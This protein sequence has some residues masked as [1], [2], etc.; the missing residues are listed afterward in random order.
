MAENGGGGSSV[1]GDGKRRRVGEES[2]LSVAQ[3][4]G[5]PSTSLSSSSALY[6]VHE[7]SAMDLDLDSHSQEGVNG[8]TLSNGVNS[9][10]NTS[11]SS[12]AAPQ[13]TSLRFGTSAARFTSTPARPSPL[14]QSVRADSS[15][16]GSPSSIHRNQDQSNSGSSSTPEV[17][18]KTNGGA[19]NHDVAKAGQAKALAIFAEIVSSAS[20]PNNDD[21]VCV[22]CGFICLFIQC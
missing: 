3:P 13:T 7:S 4:S 16:P 14:R 21:K 20:Q 10:T 1:A 18:V 17:S 8:S 12:S 2:Y 5:P 15:S 6:T 9:S 11:T 19:G 22:S